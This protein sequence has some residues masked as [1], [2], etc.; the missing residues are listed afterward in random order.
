MQKQSN[1]G[2][3]HQEV[4]VNIELSTRV[5]DEVK[6]LI[7]IWYSEGFLH[8]LNNPSK[9]AFDRKERYEG[10]LLFL[11]KSLEYRCALT[12]IIESWPHGQDSKDDLI[13]LLS[14]SD[15]T[16]NRN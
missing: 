4:C 9:T 13:N 6:E 12:A 11:M 2:R 8:A 10:T 14:L 7:E 15:P 5:F 1:Q 3:N 16:L